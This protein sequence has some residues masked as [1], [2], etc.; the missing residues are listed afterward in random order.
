MQ[1]IYTMW[2]VKFK[3]EDLNKIGQDSFMARSKEEA[4][5]SFRACYRH[6]VYTI[7]EV[8]NTNVTWE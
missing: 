6:H 8:T 2:E 1:D 5:S 4:V 7:L 3:N